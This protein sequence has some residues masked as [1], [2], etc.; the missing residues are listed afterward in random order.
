M[1]STFWAS[2]ILVGLFCER[3]WTAEGNAKRLRGQPHR[4]ALFGKAKCESQVGI[5]R[6]L[7]HI[8][9]DGEAAYWRN[10]TVGDD[11]TPNF[12]PKT[13]QQGDKNATFK[14][15]WKTGCQRMMPDWTVVLTSK[16]F[17]FVK[18]HIKILLFTLND[19]PGL[20]A[21]IHMQGLLLQ[22]SNRP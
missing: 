17:A 13:K 21:E 22:Y 11:F 12:Y 9:L 15:E 19:F 10:A 1:R 6:V 4:R 18:L 20:S 2:L 16:P 3:F 7:H 8:F 14:Y 5:P